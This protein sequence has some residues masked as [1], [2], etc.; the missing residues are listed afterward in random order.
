M[1]RT[2]KESGGGRKGKG[3]FPRN[4]RVMKCRL[5]GEAALQGRREGKFGVRANRVSRWGGPAGNRHARL[6]VRMERE[7]SIA[8]I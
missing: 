8:Q 5:D 6:T 4:W 1:T 7:S 2:H 3:S